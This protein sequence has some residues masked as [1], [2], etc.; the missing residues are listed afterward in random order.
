MRKGRNTGH[1]DEIQ[2]EK[3]FGEPN[4]LFLIKFQ[5]AHALSDRFLPPDPHLLIGSVRNPVGWCGKVTQLQLPDFEFVVSTVWLPREEVKGPAMFWAC[6][7][8]AEHNSKVFNV[9]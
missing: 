8:G 3:A 1:C 4:I 7:A 2:S 9:K 5:V 6:N